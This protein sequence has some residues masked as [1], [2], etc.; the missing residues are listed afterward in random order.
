MSN[1][2]ATSLDCS[3]PG[4]SVHRTSQAKILVWVDISSSREFSPTQ[5][6]NVHWQV[7]SLPLSPQGSPTKKSK[8]IKMDNFRD[9]LALKVYGPPLE[10]KKKINPSLD[11]TLIGYSRWISPESICFTVNQSLI[12][13]STLLSICVIKLS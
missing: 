4:S 1:S 13:S 9:P 2:F 3:P 7:D 11:Y 12:K 10:K 8:G 5:G 6:S